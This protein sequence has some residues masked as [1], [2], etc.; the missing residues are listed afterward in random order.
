MLRKLGFVIG[1]IWICAGGRLQADDALLEQFYGNG[2]HAYNQ[3]DYRGAYDA[4]TAAINGGTNDP[5]AFYF[6]GLTYLQMGQV[7]EAQA[8]FKA[9]AERE[10]GDS[11]NFYPVNQS[12]E[13]I[14]GRSRQFLEQYRAVV[15]AAAVQRKEAE[16]RARY[17][18]RAAAEQDVLRRVPPTV[19]PPAPAPSNGAPSN[20]EPSP[21][22]TT[23]ENPFAKPA[24]NAEAPSASKTEDRTPEKTTP[25]E[26]KNPF[27]SEPS[28]PEAKPEATKPAA[29]P[30]TNS[31]DPFSEPTKDA[32]PAK[33]NGSSPMSAIHNDSA[34]KPAGGSVGGLF[35]AVAKG[36]QGDQTHASAPP[37]AAAVPDFVKGLMG[38]S[39][40]SAPTTPEA[41]SGQPQ[42]VDRAPPPAMAPPATPPQASPAPA[43]PAASGEMPAATQPAAPAGTTPQPNP[44]EAPK[45]NDNPF[46]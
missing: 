22:A 16:H 24:D 28:K 32:V 46:N 14:Q 7:G 44:A 26:D 23:D 8:D 42:A 37:S 18:E 31:D 2:V 3:G 35:R 34:V 11:A 36:L 9:G 10:V 45:D 33:S 21:A 17:E 13:R 40:A 12:L 30:P 6:R 4:L 27:D 1:I 25:A 29:S 5:R 19:L 39:P 20:S 41:N 43:T 38:S 15:H